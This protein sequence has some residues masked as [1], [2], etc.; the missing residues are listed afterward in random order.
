MFA[1]QP[2]L[3]TDFFL[4]LMYSLSTDLAKQL[5]ETQSRERLQT[6]EQSNRKS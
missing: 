1:F 2:C 4:P 3:G 6:K 5:L